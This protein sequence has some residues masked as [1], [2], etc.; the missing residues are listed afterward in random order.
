M[1]FLDFHCIFNFRISSCL[2]MKL[3]S[4][5]SDVPNVF[6]RTFDHRSS[7]LE[8]KI[9]IFTSLLNGLLRFQSDSSDNMLINL[10]RQWASSDRHTRINY[11][12]YPPLVAENRRGLP[13]V[14][15]SFIF[16]GLSKMDE[17]ERKKEGNIV[18][19]EVGGVKEKEIKKQG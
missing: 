13:R 4:N 19:V 15:D 16:S 9:F 17:F 7:W 14:I 2:Q 1:S 10:Q 8:M 12:E 6:S 11:R 18:Q 5:L 3:I